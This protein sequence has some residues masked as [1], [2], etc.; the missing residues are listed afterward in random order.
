[1]K[2]AARSGT[3]D[4][5]WLIPDERGSIVA[6]TNASGAA[7]AVNSYDEYGIPASTNVGRFQ[8][9][10]QAWLPEIGMYYYKARM[11]SATLGRFM[12]TDPI[13]YGDG[14]NMYG[15]VSGDPVNNTDP[16]G[17]YQ[18]DG[19]KAECGAVSEALSTVRDAAQSGK[20]SNSQVKILN[21][22]LKTWGTEGAKNGVVVTFRAGAVINA[23]ARGPAVAVTAWS[24]KH[25]SAVIVLPQN[26]GKLYNSRV[27]DPMKNQRY[28]NRFSPRDERGNVIA[29]EGQHA[30]DQLRA[31]GR[32]GTNDANAERR[33]YEAGRA[34]NRANGTVPL[35]D[36]YGPDQGDE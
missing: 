5:R 32:A 8:Y 33:G 27:G 3:T 29:H 22:V 18:C 21:G 2:A 12:Q 14:M 7:I 35:R 6:V 24:D 36:L 1:M 23:M 4:R 31:G 25:K 19:T 26:F 13:G 10:G 16:T 30:R 28:P 11:Y 20:L 17:L 15:Y 34:V 9:T